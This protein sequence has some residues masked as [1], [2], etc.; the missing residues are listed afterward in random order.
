MCRE[1]VAALASEAQARTRMRRCMGG[2]DD[3]DDDDVF[4]KTVN[5]FLFQFENSD[6]DLTSTRLSRIF[7]EKCK[8]RQYSSVCFF[9]FSKK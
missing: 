5:F 1:R 7:V 2:D 9:S 8:L 4:G 6:G 3:D